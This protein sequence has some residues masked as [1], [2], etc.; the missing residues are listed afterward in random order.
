MS[1]QRRKPQPPAVQP[2]SSKSLSRSPPLCC[3]SRVG[4]ADDCDTQALAMDCP[5]DALRSPSPRSLD[6]PSPRL[7]VRLLCEA[8]LWL[9][10]DAE[11]FESPRTSVRLKA[12]E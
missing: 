5:Q 10:S 2:S 4:T 7:R 6:L 1:R 8:R 3:D 9:L 12:S 11:L